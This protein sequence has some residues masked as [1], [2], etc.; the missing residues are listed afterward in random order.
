MRQWR[1]V[2]SGIGSSEKINNISYEARW[3]FILLITVQDDMAV[4]QYTKPKLKTL[5]AGS[6]EWTTEDIY[7][8]LTELDHV[9]LIQIN[10]DHI[11][12]I[13]GETKNGN[14]YKWKSPQLYDIPSLKKVATRLKQ[15]YNRRTTNNEKLKPNTEK[16]KKNNEKYE[17]S[18]SNTENIRQHGTRFSSLNRNN[19]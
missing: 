6:T 15:S 7:R 9:E 16:G 5:C 3:L 2:Y 12:I 18:K 1:K 11:Y 8:L 19:K 4:Y 13:D 14:L 17:L 10:D